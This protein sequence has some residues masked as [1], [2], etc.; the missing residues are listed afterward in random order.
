MDAKCAPLVTD[1]FSYCYERDFLDS[2][3][4]D[5]K[6]DDIE[7]FNSTSWYLDDLYNIDN[8]YFEGMDITFIHLNYKWIPFI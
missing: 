6:V 8:P 5:N 3:K 7:A 1:L 4:H 2:L